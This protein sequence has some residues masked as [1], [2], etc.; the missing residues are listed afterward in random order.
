MGEAINLVENFKVENVIFNCGEYNDL[1][2]ELINVLDKKK[3]NYYSYIKELNIDK[4]KLQFLNT[5]IYDN[6]NDNSSVVYF[7]HN[8]YKFLF[9][10]DA[11]IKREK[12]EQENARLYQSKETF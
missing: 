9:M 10:G 2:K 3:I 11:S 12:V 8:N 5:S 6:E 7:N 1:E 4:Y